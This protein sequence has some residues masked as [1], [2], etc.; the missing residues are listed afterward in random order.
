MVDVHGS[1]YT[2]EASD[3][4][5]PT[6]TL[7]YMS[8]PNRQNSLATWVRQGGKLWALGSGFGNATNTPWNNINN[9][10]GETRVYSSSGFR[11]ELISGRF[12][13]DL[14]HWRSEFRVQQVEFPA[15]TSA[16]FPIGG[17]PRAPDYAL[18]PSQLAF[19]APATDPIWP[20]RSHYDYYPLPAV[21]SI[22][23]LSQPNH[24][25][26]DKNP[27]PRHQD[28]VQALDTLMVVT[29]P[30]LPDPGPNPAVDRIVNPVMT[31]YYGLDCGP[32]VFSGFDLWSWSRADCVRLVDAV[33]HGIWGLSRQSDA[34]GPR[35][36]L[37]AR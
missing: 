15:I 34:G 30:G 20:F 33:L 11:P 1:E 2:R 32:V 3:Q 4:L 29:G 10:E 9:D 24:I 35:A 28:E 13:Y 7:R 5:L 18:L 17:S 27:S 14:A 25:L 8:Q 21:C 37:K 12:M 36:A 31:Y 26:E 23:Y 16:P 19:R 22:E 6:T